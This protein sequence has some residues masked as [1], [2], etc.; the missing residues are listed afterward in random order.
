MKGMQRGFMFCLAVALAIGL[1]MP[2]LQAF[3]IDDFS[4][5]Q[6]ITRLATSG[7]GTTYGSIAGGMMGGWRAT[8]VTLSSGTLGRVRS[9]VAPGDF[10]PIGD[11]TL[12]STGD[13]L[14]YVTYWWD[15]DNDSAIDFGNNYNYTFGGADRL[16]GTLAGAPG[17][18]ESVTFTAYSD[19]G[20]SSASQ[21]FTIPSGGSS[22]FWI[23]YSSFIGVDFSNLNALSMRLNSAAT[24]NQYTYL[25]GP[26]GLEGTTTV[27]EPGT[28][29]LMGVLLSMGGAAFRRMKAG[30]K[31]DEQK[32]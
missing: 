14:G 28:F 25:T 27:P 2:S 17:S 24:D 29:A 6:T 15:G 1:T 3:V 32:V 26:V 7:A 22:E 5:P 8:G 18:S 23:P 30:Q 20:A 9:T 12:T 4:N 16:H 10:D 13:S 11:A 21:T 31:T 19:G